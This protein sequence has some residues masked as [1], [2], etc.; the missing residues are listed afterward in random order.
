M[1]NAAH[2][3]HI[4]HHVG[5]HHSTTSS[6]HASSKA[7]SMGG[8]KTGPK[9]K[10]KSGKSISKGATVQPRKGPQARRKKG[11]TKRRT[12]FVKQ[13]TAGRKTKAIRKLLFAQT[14]L[15]QAE[16]S[17]AQA[18]QRRRRALLKLAFMMARRVLRPLALAPARLALKNSIQPVVRERL[19]TMVWQP[20][21]IL[22]TARPI[23]A[24]K[25][26]EQTVAV[27][28]GATC[29]GSPFLS[30]VLAPNHH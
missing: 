25:Q 20:R 9:V 17:C 1:L 8:T 12:G 10:Q 18:R 29:A 22:S 30:R 24:W 5:S 7:K 13:R 3:H 19:L 23:Q 4:H 15:V 26:E 27:Q 28:V 16:Q 2:H 14:N 11:S 6:K 21:F